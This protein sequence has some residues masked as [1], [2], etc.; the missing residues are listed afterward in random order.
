MPFGTISLLLALLTPVSFVLSCFAISF[1]CD[2]FLDKTNPFT[3]LILLLATFSIHAVLLLLTV[4][5][6]IIGLCQPH[7][8]KQFRLQ[9]MFSRLGIFIALLPVILLMSCVVIA[10]LVLIYEVDLLA[11]LETFG[12]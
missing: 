2:N 10:I 8:P 5:F 1:I 9:K 7:V 12:I 11:L 4:I 3:G 6:G